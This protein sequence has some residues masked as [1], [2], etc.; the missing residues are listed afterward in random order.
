[1]NKIQSIMLTVLVVAVSFFA[2]DSFAGY[3]EESTTGVL[4]YD[5]VSYHTGGKP[6]RGDGN[7]LVVVNDVTYL[8]A[9]EANKNAF[10]ANPEKYLPAF[11]GYCAFGVS[12]NK[13]FVGDP[14]VWKIVDGTLYL[15]LDKNI[16]KEWKKDIPG[17]IVKA[18]QNWPKIK[19]KAPSD[20]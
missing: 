7:N 2:V 8:F 14:E 12:V 18:N 6:F 3:V 17:N 13:K 19:N 1:M 16:Q 11:G 5:L 10:E 9:N 20:L 15:N 4:G